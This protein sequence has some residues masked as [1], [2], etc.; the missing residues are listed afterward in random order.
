MVL[1]VISMK[2]CCS[3]LIGV[4]KFGAEQ[5]AIKITDTKYGVAANSLEVL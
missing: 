1:S 3:V 4:S 5:D 2:A